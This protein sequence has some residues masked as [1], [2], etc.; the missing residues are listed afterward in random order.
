MIRAQD[1]IEWGKSQ[2]FTY[3]GDKN[4]VIDGFSSLSRYKK[5]SLTWIKKAGISQQ[6]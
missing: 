2:V 4:L 1:I 6:Q 5:G 3:E